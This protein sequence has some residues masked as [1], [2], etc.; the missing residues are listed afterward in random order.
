MGIISESWATPVSGSPFYIW[1]EKLRRVKIALKN[2]AKLVTSPAQRKTN[3]MLALEVHRLN[4]EATQ[5]SRKDLDK[6]VS[7]RQ[8]LHAA[9]RQEEES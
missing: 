6:E 3:A 5:L 1:E 8:E 4:M 9:C 7:L 2:W